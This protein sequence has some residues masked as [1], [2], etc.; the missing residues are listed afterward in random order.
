[1]IHARLAIR[2]A[3]MS[4]AVGS[5]HRVFFSGIDSVSPGSPKNGRQRPVVGFKVLRSYH[6]KF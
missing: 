2:H 3:R 5:A 4:K 1:M 6:D